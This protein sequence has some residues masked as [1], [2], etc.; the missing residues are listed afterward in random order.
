MQ[1]RLDRNPQFAGWS[2][3]AAKLAVVATAVTFLASFTSGARAENPPQKDPK[4]GAKPIPPPPWIVNGQVRDE[5]GRPIEGAEVR[6]N[7]GMG[8]LACTGITETDRDGRYSFRFGPGI[9]GP[10]FQAAIVHAS[11]PGRT[12]RDLG[13]Q[14]LFSAAF[15]AVRKSRDVDPERTFL[16]NQPRTVDFVLVP[17][18]KIELTIDNDQPRPIGPTSVALVGDTMPP[19]CSVAADGTTNEHGLLTLHEVPTGYEWRFEVSKPGSGETL[20]S[21]PFTLPKAREYGVRLQVEKVPQL[22]TSIL[23]IRGF[24]QAGKDVRNEVLGLDPFAEQPG[25]P[26]VQ[27]RGHDLLRKIG[28]ANRFWLGEPPGS[29]K[30][31][32]YTLHDLDG[33]TTH[34][35]I[36]ADRDVPLDTLHGPF[37]VPAL[38]ISCSPTNSSIF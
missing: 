6:V 29:V 1:T 11:T 5:A 27:K 34:N 14:G 7:A 38:R 33:Q 26:D 9:L 22:A 2:V 8:T 20:R 31:W 19:G 18:A 10:D 37:Y 25:G 17:A 4:I 35:R 30:T 16:P 24:G 3:R 13:R 28:E 23:T 12:E 21:R 15:R 36:P 32:S